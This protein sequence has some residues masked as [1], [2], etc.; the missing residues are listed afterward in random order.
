LVY[1]DD[2]LIGKRT[3]I[4]IGLA[5]AL[6]SCQP[7]DVVPGYQ[8]H[9][10]NDS[11]DVV[12]IRVSG[13]GVDVPSGL[14]EAGGTFL[15]AANS[16]VW[17]PFVHANVDVLA[18]GQGVV[19]PSVVTVLDQTCNERWTTPVLTGRLR[20]TIGSKPDV[21]EET[22]AAPGES[23]AGYVAQRCRTR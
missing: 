12:L 2:I 10:I 16:D 11:S 23:L 13:H 20:L 6:I 19:Q 7:A 9:V 1:Q 22:N 14:A 8:L 17:T 15:V 18:N 3:Q 4:L 21:A 5:V